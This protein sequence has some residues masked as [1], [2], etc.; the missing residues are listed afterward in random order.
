MKRLAFLLSLFA[1]YS[2]VAQSLHAAPAPAFSLP[3]TVGLPPMVADR[4][5]YNARVFT[6][7]PDVTKRW[8]TAVAM[9]GE[10]ILWVGDDASVLSFAGPATLREDAHGATMTAGIVDA[11]EHKVPPF[12]A[13]PDPTNGRPFGDLCPVFGFTPEGQ[14]YL[15]TDPT[16]DEVVAALQGC[17][18]EAPRRRS[19]FLFAQKFYLTSKG[20]HVL[21]ELTAASPDKAATGFDGSE[22]HGLVGNARAFKAAG[23][24]DPATNP[25]GVGVADPFGGFYGRVR[26]PQTGKVE[27]DGW[28]QELAQVPHFAALVADLPDAVLAAIYKQGL[29]KALSM[30]VTS[31]TDVFFAG[32][33]AKAATVRALV[34]HPVDL[35]VACL[36]LSDG[37]ACPDSLRNRWGYLW[38]K[39][40]HAGA[41]KSCRGWASYGYKSPAQQCPSVSSPWW[42]GAPDIT[43]AQLEN[44]YRRVKNGD[45][46]CGMFHVFGG[47]SVEAA[48]STAQ[49]EGM[50]GQCVTFEHTDMAAA[51]TRAKVR[52]LGF[53]FIQNLPHRT[54]EADIAS[55]YQPVEAA[56]ALR[57]A[58]LAAEGGKLALGGDEFGPDSTPPN[59]QIAD[60][61]DAVRPGERMGAEDGFI[62]YTRN[63]A[64]AR[65][66]TAGMLVSG[67]PATLVQW[68]RNILSGL[69]GDMRA[70]K[71]TRVL[72]RGQQVFT[73][74]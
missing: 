37:D 13:I 11:H 46:V 31:V 17:N 36:P 9:K 38:V 70:G 41:I 44:A 39:W 54:L 22:G 72:V 45:K 5:I 53:W 8:A 62:A 10:S 69:P 25:G 60:L 65:R 57:F 56:E 49:R 66:E 26:N 40:F 3:Q 50:A 34:N 68:D 27:L 58:T 48:A 19:V 6:S 7:Q 71:V 59:V 51:S 20:H 74:P 35:T 4:V 52:A 42:Y 64:L 2:V 16:W 29:D 43:T 1:S 55:H 63:S 21:N 30:G 47:N 18:A 33:P 12:D 32:G 67:Y 24:Y 28:A 14:P 15:N 61:M 23:I 73:A